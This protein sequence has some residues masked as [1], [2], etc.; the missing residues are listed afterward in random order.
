MHLNT[1][2]AAS[3][4][5]LL[6]ARQ[7]RNT[8]NEQCFPRKS[9]PQ[10][11]AHLDH[12]GELKRIRV[13]VDPR[14]EAAAIADRI[15]GLRDGGPALLFQQVNGSSLPV[16]M[17]LFGSESRMKAALG[18]RSFGDLPALMNSFLVSDASS[19]H[20]HLLSA[21]DQ[22]DLISEPS[23]AALPHLVS[24]PGD[25]QPVHDGIFFTL[26][27]VV[28]ADADTG[29]HNLGIYRVARFSDTELGL[30]WSSGSGGFLHHQSWKN[31][32]K[33]MPVA[34]LLGADPITT[35]CASLPL[36]SGMDELSLAGFLQGGPLLVRRCKRSSLVVPESSGVVIEGIVSPNETRNEGAFGNHTGTYEG[37]GGV[38]LMQVQAVSRRHDAVIS[39]TLV[40]PPPKENYWFA[41][42]GSRLML[43]L[44]QREAP[45]IVDISLPRE[46]IYHGAALVA[47]RK[48][49]PGQALWVMETLW[50]KTWMKSARLLVIIDADIPI[51]DF[52]QIYWRMMNQTVWGRDLVLGD[53]GDPTKRYGG[54]LGIDATRKLIGEGGCDARPDAVCWPDSMVKLIDAR[55][56]EYGLT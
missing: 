54:R 23:L 3:S 4:S 24:W 43:P 42:A 7:E 2:R 28:T 19:C 33:A 32:G 14:F 17:N 11:I 37:G 20:P 12:L 50:K 5:H 31:K 9:L 56:K 53:K 35:F 34:I 30:H 26:A 29:Q 49:E 13:P 27:L 21:P 18:I 36:P 25:G 16:A 15:M 45:E 41:A 47:I 40:G 6:T 52:R 8:V 1:N 10:F 55:W 22:A 39:Q 48:T 46:A 38:P 44:L 51:T